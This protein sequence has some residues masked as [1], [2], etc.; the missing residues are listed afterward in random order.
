MIPNVTNLVMIRL[1]NSKDFLTWH[2]QFTATLASYGLLC[3]VDGS[4]PPSATAITSSAGKSIPIPDFYDWMWNYQSIRSWIFAT[5]SPEVLVY[6]RDRPTYFHLWERSINDFCILI[7]LE[8]LNLNVYLLL[9]A[10]L[11]LKLWMPICIILR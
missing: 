10:S 6:V 7:W 5:L 3:F 4:Y 8:P 9:F 2:T 11:I 1:S